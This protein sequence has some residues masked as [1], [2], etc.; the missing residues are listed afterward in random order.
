MLRS[1]LYTASV[2]ALSAASFAQKIETRGFERV[3][4]PVKQAGVYHLA[5]GTW[6]RGQATQLTGVAG[7]D[8]VYNCT[9]PT[10]YYFP[11]YGGLTVTCS[12]RV[13]SLSSPN[14][15]WNPAALP[16]GTVPGSAAGCANSYTIDG[17]QIGY[18]SRSVGATTSM[19]IAFY[20]SWNPTCTTP[21]VAPPQGG[22]F[23]L[24]GFPGRA[25][26]AALGCWIVNL[27]LAGATLSFNMLADGDGA[28]G[29]N[30]DDAFG[31]T[32][33]FPSATSAATW[34]GFIQTG[35]PADG[36]GTAHNG[37]GWKQFPPNTT[38]ESAGY[39]GTRFDGPSGAAAPTYPANGAVGFP[40]PGGEDGTD[41]V[42]DDGV[43]FENGFLPNG[44]ATA[45]GCYFFGG[46]IGSGGN[47]GA[48]ANFHMELYAKV[49]CA[50]PAP[51]LAY[52]FGDGLDPLVTT[53]C[54]CN[55]FGAPGNGCASSFNAN[56]ANI[57]ATGQVALDD[58]VLQGSGMNATGN[59]IFLKGDTDDAG[60]VVFGDGVRCAVGTLIRLRTVPLVAGTSAFPDSTQT[61]TLSAR[62]GTPVGSGLTGY[63]TVY[64]RNAAAAFCPPGT[65]NTA[66]GYQI[67][68]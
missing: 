52:C 16:V 22:P 36:S 54:P 11:G 40:T 23:A 4:V 14:T 50:P 8:I 6:T 53:A 26:T 41:M 56:G 43:R 65:F 46:P 51:G 13:P 19:T 34:A 42:A 3:S 20:Q 66:N 57:T 21:V 15:V 7:S 55:N 29:A 35:C 59:S 39:D 10:G 33:T 48:Y 32:F 17:F 38:V 5:T 1:S 31:W 28:Y 63:Y 24:A 27:D 58:V 12:G 2:L 25:S 61:I 62:G 45:A 64:Y 60:G 30:T 49:S 68:W 67:T 37:I 18:C 47:D 9:L 44:A